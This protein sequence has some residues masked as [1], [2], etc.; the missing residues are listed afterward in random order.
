M[1]GCRPTLDR[2]AALGAHIL[3]VGLQQPRIAGVVQVGAQALVH[4]AL[5]Q[6]RVG[7]RPGQF[8]AAALADGVGEITALPGEPPAGG[9]YGLWPGNGNRQP[10]H[11]P[12]GISR[13]LGSHKL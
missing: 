5:A 3:A 2:G 8:D 1:V 6:R 7:H 9:K 11:K 10:K 4:D 13:I 12:L